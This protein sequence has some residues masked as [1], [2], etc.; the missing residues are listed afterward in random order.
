[1]TEW[2]EST[3]RLGV[4]WVWVALLPAIAVLVYWLYRLTHPAP[5]PGRRWLLTGLRTVAVGL[6]LL[7][8]LE[9]VYSWY[10]SDQTRP[11]LTLLV[12]T[13]PSMGV[14]DGGKTR[15]QRV[16]EV[17]LDPAWNQA[18]ATCD[19]EALGFAEHPAA[20]GLDTLAR[21]A[22]SGSA[23]DLAAALEGLPSRR[24]DPG[25]PRALLLLSDGRRNLGPDPTAV[26]RGL[27]LPVY[28]LSVGTA[29]TPPDAAIPGLDAPV[30]LHA[31]RSTLV[32]VTLSAW[33]RAGQAARVRLYDDTVSVATVDCQLPADGVDLKLVLPWR[34]TTPGGHLLRA[35]LDSLPGETWRDNDEAR[36][37]T[38]VR[39]RPARVLLVAGGPG[40]DLA[41]LSRSLAVDS[42]LS[43][44][45][46]TYRGQG[47]LS[48]VGATAAGRPAEQDAIVLLDP[49]LDLLRGP[50]GSEIAAR[51]R[52]GAGLLFLG[53]PR[54]AGWWGAPQ[55]LAEV[56]PVL[57]GSGF[58]TE[59]IPLVWVTDG[60]LGPW[61]VGPGGA[62]AWAA[63]PPLPGYLVVTGLRPG[64][65]RLVEA[66]GGSR[67]PVLVAGS[68]GLGR[69]V[70]GLSGSFWRLDLLTSGVD[71]DP[72]AVR[73]FWLACVRWL[74]YAPPGGSLRVTTDRSSYRSGERV[75]FQAQLQDDNPALVE[76]AVSV[77]L[78]T[79][80]GALSLQPQGNGRYQGTWPDLPAGLYSFAAQATRGGQ[81]LG[82]DQ[83]RFV[84]EPRTVESAD[85]RADPEQLRAVAAASGGRSRPLAE[86]RAV[87][88][89]LPLRAR[90]Q[91]RQVDLR[92]WPSTV[93]VALIVVLLSAEWLLRRRWG[94]V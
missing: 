9:P 27:G 41:F 11:L 76:A 4:A 60:S 19:I 24:H 79:P 82:Q 43:L 62:A 12:D 7:A 85:L 1:M 49:P 28:A 66:A 63:L 70:A 34:P 21:W 5:D 67:A 88:A 71:G 46:Q 25:V 26:A 52:Q 74:A 42:S 81:P 37:L 87:L 38:T 10:R 65:T 8:L 59:D 15:F 89:D 39:A 36:L 53:G 44:V 40:P 86:W 6:L 31:G 75:T 69:V 56:L 32:S 33:S 72:Q 17:L 14:D 18:L 91:R 29:A 55:P 20:M 61:P 83:G 80:P 77:S 30:P 13:S 54:T 73:Q 64:A 84:V 45:A 94:L 2:S 78:G 93:L 23:T 3:L 48:T 35:A 57:A 16:Q 92:L 68:C 90:L 22:P 58:V 50:L 51:V 47:A